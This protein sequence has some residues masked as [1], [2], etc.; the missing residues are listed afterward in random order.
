MC[1]GLPLRISSEEIIKY[2]D[3]INEYMADL[4]ERFDKMPSSST[5][6]DRG[7]SFFSDEEFA[8]IQSMLDEMAYA[9]AAIADIGVKKNEYTEKE[10]AFLG[11]LFSFSKI[12]GTKMEYG[13]L[14]GE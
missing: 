3:N 13:R 9:H 4:N 14:K 2:F 8:Y 1:E 10:E 5:V 11:A 12:V 6:L 7:D